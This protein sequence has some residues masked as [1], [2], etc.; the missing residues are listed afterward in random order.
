MGSVF[1]MTS[2]SKHMNQF[3]PVG[4]CRW[5]G[6]YLSSVLNINAPP[7]PLT[8]VFSTGLGLHA[9]L[10][11]NITSIYLEN[12]SSHK[13]AMPDTT[14]TAGSDEVMCEQ[15]FNSLANT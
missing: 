5:S 9:S 14:A 8:F 2:V 3:Q 10:S 13:S 6:Q 1:E 7:P 11:N 15:P 12:V 4:W